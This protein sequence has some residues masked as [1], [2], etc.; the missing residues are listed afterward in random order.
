M[1]TRYTLTQM[2]VLAEF[3][4]TLGAALDPE[5]FPA[6]FNVAPTQKVPVIVD[7]GDSRRVVSMPFGIL[8]PARPP[9]K[10]GLL[11]VTARSESMTEKPTFREATAHRRCLVPADG[12]FE[13]EKAGTARL[14]HYLTLKNR[15]PF[16]FAGLWQTGTDAEP[17]GF[18]IVTTEPNALLSPFH[19]RMPVILGPNTGP[20]WLGNQP[21]PSETLRR[22]CR[23][24][25]AEIM[26][27]HR[28]DPRVNN[29]RY[30]A[31]DTIAPLPA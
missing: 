18:A 24:L 16:C 10:R 21:L 25:P 1:C 17:G 9:A 19:D 27:S 5:R 23:P 15:R 26:E 7:E 29:V 20:A 14:P 4:Q 11:V 22:L 2:Q 13:W 28:V 6:R 3:C 8:L 12:F 30:E 31:P